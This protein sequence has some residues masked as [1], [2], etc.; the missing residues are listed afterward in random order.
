MAGP[1]WRVAFRR[2]TDKQ[3]T[4]P[5]I[6]R[7]LSSERVELIASARRQPRPT[8]GIFVAITV[9][10]CTFAV[11]REAA[12]IDH[13]SHNVLD[14]KTRLHG[15]LAVAC[16]VPVA[17][18]AVIGVTAFPMSILTGRRCRTSGRRARSTS[19]TR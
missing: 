6:P 16:R 4:G 5:L 1:P 10:N 14:A 12:M 11:E 7:L 13:G 17:N 19:S 8:N 15:S 2:G 9:R 3:T 18:L